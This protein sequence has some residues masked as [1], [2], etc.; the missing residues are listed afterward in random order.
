MSRARSGPVIVCLGLVLATAL[1]AGADPGRITKYVFPDGTVVYSDKPVPGAT[2]VSEIVVPPAP[3]P[4]AAKTPAAEPATSAGDTAT[5]PPAPD[6]EP[7][8]IAEAHDGKCHLR[9]TSGW[10]WV[11]IRIE[12]LDPGEHF[13]FELRANDQLTLNKATAT[14]LGEGGWLLYPA[15]L[16]KSGSNAIIVKSSHCE[17]SASFRWPP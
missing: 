1:P 15:L 11:E 5:P 14:D 13:V 9:V 3:P 10:Q 12:G 4:P 16:A 2:A 8:L 7:P 17:L 6:D